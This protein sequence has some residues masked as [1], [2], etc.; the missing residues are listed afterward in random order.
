[1]STQTPPPAGDSDVVS[2]ARQDLINTKGYPASEIT[3]ISYED[4]TWPNSALGCPKTGMM[5]AQVLTPGYR[6]VLGWK[7]LK[8]TY[9]GKAGSPPFRCQFLE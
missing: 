6:I 7:D 4:V 2:Q 1:M 8:Y 3:L 9:H 5:Y